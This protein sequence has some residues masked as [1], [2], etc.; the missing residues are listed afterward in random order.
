[1]SS[2]WSVAPYFHVPDIHQAVEYYQDKL[3]FTYSQLWG[4]PP[5]FVMMRR[6]GAVIM[7]SSIPLAEKYPE[8][9]SPNRKVDHHAWDA[10]IWIGTADIHELYNELKGKG[11]I[12][13]HE[14]MKKE[15]YGMYELEVED[16]WGYVICFGQNLEE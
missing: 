13:S 11:A 2:E 10:Y 3:G 12:I 1:M 16:P 5:N 4:D 8:L 6:E 15:Y 9:L 14:P 7:I